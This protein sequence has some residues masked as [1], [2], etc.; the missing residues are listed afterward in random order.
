MF[1]MMAA[2][3]PKWLNVLNVLWITTAFF[4]VCKGAVNNRPIIGVLAQTTYDEMAEYGPSYIA[5]SYVKFL[6]SAGARVV[7]IAV[8]QTQDYYVKLFS[9]LNG[10]LF[11]GGSQYLETSGYGKAGR[12]LYDL[13]VKANDNGDYFPLWGTCLGFELLIYL[14][15]EENLMTYT[16][17]T[18][19]AYPVYFQKDFKTTRLFASAPEKI[20]QILEN[21]NVTFN[22]HHNG[23]TPKNFSTSAKLKSFYKIISTNFDKNGLEFI[24]MTEAYKY[25]FYASQW[26]PEKNIFE[27]TVKERINHSKDA[28]AASLYFTN[29]FVNEARKNFHK[30]PNPAEEEAALIYNYKPMYTGKISSYD[31]SY[32]FGV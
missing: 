14:T 8:N 22:A 27:W 20:I 18:N 9:S 6:E 12:I 31:Q 28:M 16:N 17:S 24:S 2:L 3:R 25:P 19:I 21:E 29:F 7:P 11:P 5:A 23:V 1:S 10:V 4:A 32:F 15:A 26:H 13:A 30:F